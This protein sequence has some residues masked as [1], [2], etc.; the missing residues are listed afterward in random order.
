MAHAN[1]DQ[2]LS[3]RTRV[4]LPAHICGFVGCHTAKIL[5][6]SS[7]GA[8]V[9]TSAPLESGAQIILGWDGVDR[10]AVVIWRLGCSIG[11]RFTAG[12]D[13]LVHSCERS[14]I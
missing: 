1:G 9:K 8:K 11:L 2:R 7:E 4:Q 12:P 6:L 10:P 5:N 14:R 3:T 13:E